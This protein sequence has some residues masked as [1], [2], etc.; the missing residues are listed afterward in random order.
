[1]MHGTRTLS[2]IKHSG[3]RTRRKRQKYAASAEGIGYH[4]SVCRR[5]AP[6]RDTFGAFERAVH[7]V[8]IHGIRTR[9]AATCANGKLGQVPRLRRRA[10][11]K[12]R[13][14]LFQLV[15]SAVKCE[16]RVERKAQNA[17]GGDVFAAQLIANI[18]DILRNIKRFNIPFKRGKRL[19]NGCIA[20][21]HKI[22]LAV[23]LEI[24]IR[25]RPRGRKNA[26]SHRAR[27]LGNNAYPAVLGSKQS[28]YLIVVA[29]RKLP[30]NEGI[31]ADIPNCHIL[32]PFKNLLV[33]ILFVVAEIA[34]ESRAVTPILLDL[35]PKVK[36]YLRSRDLF[37]LL[38]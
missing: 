22:A 35:Y 38:P 12:R 34:D 33:D 4:L 14:D 31:H 30:Y 17:L 28:E 23:K 3:K 37:K 1:M 6:A 5:A 18:R 16:K 26:A 27:A 13:L 2:E 10:K 29:V 9:R 7:Y 36:I 32:T 25:K 15:A 19:D 21:P 20:H 24:R 8:K 11:L